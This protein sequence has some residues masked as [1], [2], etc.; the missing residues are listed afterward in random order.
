MKVKLAATAMNKPIL[1][2]K[3]KAMLRSQAAERNSLVTVFGL[4]MISADKD[5]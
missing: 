3:D 5:C 1:K 4:R 2:D